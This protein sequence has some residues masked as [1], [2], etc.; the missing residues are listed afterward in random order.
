MTARTRSWISVRLVVGALVGWF[1]IDQV[2]GLPANIM[3][4]GVVAIAVGV[5]ALDRWIG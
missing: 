4:A 5:V 3:I 2:V 1:T